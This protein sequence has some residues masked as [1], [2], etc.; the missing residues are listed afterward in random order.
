MA[1]AMFEKGD[2][3]ACHQ[4]G[5]RLLNAARECVWPGRFATFKGFWHA[6]TKG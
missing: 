1:V 6:T 4:Q 2:L 3:Q 5:L